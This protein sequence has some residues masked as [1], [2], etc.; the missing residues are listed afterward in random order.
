MTAHI[1]KGAGSVI[2]PSAPVKRYQ[3]IYIILF[4]SCTQ[5]QI[6]IQF[7]WNLFFNIVGA[8][9]SF[10]GSVDLLSDVQGTFNDFFDS[11]DYVGPR[12]LHYKQP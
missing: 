2:P 11:C 7:F 10:F 9:V 3:F 5:P 6:P 8:L 4:R 1:A 12:V